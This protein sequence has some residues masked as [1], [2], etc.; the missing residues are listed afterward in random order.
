[1]N[2]KVGYSKQ[3]LESPNPI[4][5]YA[6][7]KR[8]ELSVGKAIKVLGKNASLLDYGCGEGDF[9]KKYLI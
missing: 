3:T 7:R 4:A 2:K 9:L 8:Y 1:M 5:R 6:H